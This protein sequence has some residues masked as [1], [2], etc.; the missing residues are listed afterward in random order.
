VRFALHQSKM[1]GAGI[2]PL[3]RHIVKTTWIICRSRQWSHNSSHSQTRKD[4]LLPLGYLVL[5]G[6]IGKS[7]A[8][9]LIFIHK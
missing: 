8:P 7:N 9:N 3:R 6:K 5:R 2:R 1:D 4:V